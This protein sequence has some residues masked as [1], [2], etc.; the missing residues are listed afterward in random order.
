MLIV[1]AP[2]LTQITLGDGGASGR[3][4]FDVWY[5]VACDNTPRVENVLTARTW[6]V[7]D[8]TAAS[9]LTVHWVGVEHVTNGNSEIPP[10]VDTLYNLY[11]IIAE[12]PASKGGNHEKNKLELDAASSCTFCGAVGNDADVVDAGIDIVGSPAPAL[13][14]ACTVKSYTVDA[15]RP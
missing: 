4:G 15:F 14:T 5:T 8:V 11:P 9:P 1:M 6:R 2:A 7:Y 13:L 3:S 10:L 12:P